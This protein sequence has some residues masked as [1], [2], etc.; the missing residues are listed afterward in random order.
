MAVNNAAAK[1]LEEWDIRMDKSQFENWLRERKIFKLFFDRASK[2]NL[3]KAWGGGVVIDPDRKVEI[4]YCWNIGYDTNNMA[5]AYGLWQGL[6]QLQK[7]GVDEVMVFGDSKVIIQALNGGR[8]G[9]NERTARLINIIRS[10]A[11]TFKKV[12]FFHILRGL[13]I[14]ADLASNKSIVV[15]LHELIVNSVVSI[16]IPP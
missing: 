16:D 11:K 6:K 13:N 2:G 8:R 3:G 10:K 12:N 7:K 1:K 15:D 9:K 14:L 4:E 5:E